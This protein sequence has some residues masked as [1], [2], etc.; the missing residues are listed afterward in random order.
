MSARSGRRRAG[1]AGPSAPAALI[2]GAV[3]LAGTVLLAGCASG[4]SQGSAA[5]P[6]A[7][8]AAPLATTMT[9]AG[10][11]TWAIVAMGGSAADENLFW[12]LFTRPAGSTKWALDTPPGVADNGG[13]V[14]SGTGGALTVAVRPSQGLTFSPLAITSDN[15]KTWGTGLLDADVA[16]VPDALATQGGNMLALLDDGAI[17]QAGPAGAGLTRLAAPGAVAASAAGRQCEATALTAVAY[18]ASG[19]PLAAASCAR[20][21]TVGIFARTGGTWQADGPAAP[22]GGPVRV[23]RLAGTPTGDTALLASGTGN[24]ASLLAAWTSDGTHWTTSVPLSTP[25]STR[26]ST[27]T[28]QVVA[29]GTGPGG[30]VWVL[31]AGGRAETIAGPGAA[32]QALPALPPATAALGVGPG[33]TTDALSVAGAVLTVYQLTPARTWDKAQAITVPIQYGSSS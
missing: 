8:A 12:E 1:S 15:G 31:L 11:G 16:A 22:G 29:D 30:S 4:G 20:P 18:T 10:G 17:D 14:A 19:T 5:P 27:G 26:L 6:A 3:L 24:S 7:A 2:R 33:G 21:G 32:W 9:V 28:R 25:L 23:L 13:L